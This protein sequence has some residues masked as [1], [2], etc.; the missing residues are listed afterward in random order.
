MMARQRKK[1]KEYN[2]SPYQMAIYDFIENGVGNLVVEACAGSGKSST[3]LKC[4]E[5]IP[6]D[7]RI[8][9]SA[10]NQDIVNELSDKMGNQPNVDIRTLHSLGLQFLRRNAKEGRLEPSQFKYEAY[11]MNNVGKLSDTYNDIPQAD[12]GKYVRNVAKLVDFGRYYLCQCEKDLTFV[13]ERYGIDVVADEKRVAVAVMEWGKTELGEIDFIDMIWLPNELHMKPNGLLYDYIFIDECQDMNRAEREMVMKCFKMGT[14]LISFGDEN[15]CIYSFAGSD[16]ESFRRLKELPNTTKMPLSV[17]YRCSEKIVELA[18]TMVPS[19]EPNGDGRKG[20]VLY[21][22]PFGSITDGSMV[23]CRNNAPLVQA[24]GM[25][26]KQGRKVHF[27]GGGIG[28]GLRKTLSA[29]IDDTDDGFD[30]NKTFGM[31]YSELFDIR[32]RV[33]KRYGVSE[34]EAMSSQQ[35]QSVLDDIR[36]LE[37]LSDGV[38]TNSDFFDKLNRVFD[39]NE[40]VESIEL[41]TIHKAKGT[42]SRDVFILCRSL[43]PSRTAKKDWEKRQEDNLIYVAYTRARDRFGFISEEGFDKFRR[44]SK[45]ESDR[46]SKIAGVLNRG[47]SR[48]TENH[49]Y[50]RPTNTKMQTYGRQNISS[51]KLININNADQAKRTSWMSSPKKR[52]KTNDNA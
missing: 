8:L 11:I 16:P 31:L 12:K 47:E 18:R 44:T 2:W 46:L 40:E 42:E 21:D 43:L 35:V 39:G 6:T 25:L 49:T 3:L 4:I 36:S 19:I 51:T 34:E 5:L 9:M 45:E 30:Y 13:E 37:I 28:D 15:Q 14:R 10:F 26:I 33:S 32:E 20:E 41:S 1:V 17:S 23:L 50:E 24:Y 38:R 22:I 27:R 52:K 48:A 7:K 29:A